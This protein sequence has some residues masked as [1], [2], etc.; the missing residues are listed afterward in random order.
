MRTSNYH[1]KWKLNKKTIRILLGSGAGLVIVWIIA[2]FVYFRVE[3]VEVMVSDRYTEEEIREMVLRGPLAYNS[4]L[5]P[6]LYSN[7]VE[8]VPF[9]EGF[10][11]RQ[12]NRNTIAIS[13]IEKQP[14]GCIPFLDCYMYFDRTG[15]IIESSTER[16]EKI[17]YFEGLEVDSVALEDELAIED[18]S[19]L[20]TA[21][22]LAR[23]FEKNDLIPDH[24]YFDANYAIT[25]EYGDITVMLGKDSYLEDKMARLI[26]ILPKISGQKGILHMENVTA[27]VKTITFEQEETDT[28]T[29]TGE[30]TSGETD[31]Y[32]DTGE[33]SD[34]NAE[35]GYSEEEYTENEYGDETYTEDGYA[36]DSYSE[37]GS[38]EDSYGETQGSGDG[39]EEGASD[40]EVYENST[41]QD[42]TWGSDAYSDT[43]ENSE[44]NYGEDT[45]ADGENY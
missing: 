26:A 25:L 30:D 20:N 36:E 8:D 34:T 17:P 12:V 16:D 37:D 7:S 18:E 32:T 42:N 15:K 40:E 24:I 28:G 31:T 19:V 9:V 21:V 39:T 3:N 4:V 13:V 23:I 14:V 27:D 44:E 33:T 6:G 43:D 29:D 1:K 45:G 22:S 10:E 11:V 5:A 41:Y 2:F 35:E 38:S